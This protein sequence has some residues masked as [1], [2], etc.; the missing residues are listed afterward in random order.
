[1][2]ISSKW[3]RIISYYIYI[4][5]QLWKL[6]VVVVELNFTLVLNIQQV[7]YLLKHLDP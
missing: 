2:K 7:I 5:L 4:V 6:F 1:M 3:Q